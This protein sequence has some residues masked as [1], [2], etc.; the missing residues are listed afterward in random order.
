MGNKTGDE[1]LIE[2]FKINTY[3]KILKKM[4]ETITNEIIK[5]DF[6]K[7]DCLSKVKMP[8]SVPLNPVSLPL[9]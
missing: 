3:P 6:Q 5:A 9:R 2:Y 8:N 7:N 4:Q 1:Y